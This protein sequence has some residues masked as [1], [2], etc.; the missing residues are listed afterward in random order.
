MWFV[1]GELK[2][3]TL[4]ILLALAPLSWGEKLLSETPYYCSI[5]RQGGVQS[6][7][8][9]SANFRTSP[10]QNVRLMPRGKISASVTDMASLALEKRKLP[11]ND[12]YT[13]ETNSYLLRQLNKD[14]TKF[15]NWT[16]CQARGHGKLETIDCSSESKKFSFDARTKRF[17]ASY[18][19]TWHQKTSDS[20]YAGDDAVFSF[21]T[22]APY[23]A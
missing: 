23:Y 8:L 7:T 5:E 13:R 10:D 9:Q 18:I 6:G 20:D 1:A 19:G 15:W 14:P 16:E 3:L 21:G 22:C 11:G 17:V 2:H 12:G 4:V